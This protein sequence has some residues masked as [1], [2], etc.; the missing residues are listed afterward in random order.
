MKF[1]KLKTGARRG[2]VIIGIGGSRSKIGK[3]TVATAILSRLKGWGA[4]KYTKTAI[5]SS[6]IE[7]AR[8]L[9][10]NGKDT[11]RFLE[12][13]ASA[14][15][16]VQSPGSGLSEVMPVALDRLSDL[17]GIVLEGNSAIEFVD[18][19]III[20]ITEK[21]ISRIKESG[22]RILHRADIVYYRDRG[23]IEIKDGQ[24]IKGGIEEIASTVCDMIGERK[25]IKAVLIER[26]ENG[27]IPCSVARGIAEHMK[28]PY[29]KVGKIADEL[30]IKITSCELGCF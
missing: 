3:T 4:I 6:I 21:D 22:R 25:K 5:Y 10:V 20:F 11:G 1:M 27:R 30:G 26:A 16:W 13:G 19:D 14:V 12:S 15:L 18:P 28:I 24:S 9:S 7:D 29:K 23:E 2:P 17:E 8:T